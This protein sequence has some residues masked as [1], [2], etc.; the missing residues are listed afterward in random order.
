MEDAID[1][2]SVSPVF[3]HSLGIAKSECVDSEGSSP[4]ELGNVSVPLGALRWPLL[5]RYFVAFGG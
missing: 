4:T 1:D 3:L 2:G 5:A